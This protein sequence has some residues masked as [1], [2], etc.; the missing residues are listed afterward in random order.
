MIL[1]TKPRWNWLYIPRTGQHT[2]ELPFSRRSGNNRTVNTDSENSIADPTGYCRE[3]VRKHDYEGFLISQFYPK[4][5]QGGYFALRAFA[6]ELA[7][8]QDHTSNQMIGQMRMQFWRDAVKGINDGQPPRHPIAMA[9]H[10]VSQRAHLPMYHLKRVVDARDAELYTPMH[11][12]T[13]S[14]V[15]HAESTFSSMLYL[16]LSM[17]NLTSSTLSHAASHLGC[18]QTFATLLRALPFHAK[19][20]RMII[21]AD[22]TAKNRVSQED[23]F[24]HGPQAAGIED[25]V[26]EFANTGN[27][28]LL[29]A[30]D[31][32]KDEVMGGRVPTRAMPVFLTGVCSSL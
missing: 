31:M 18:A 16:L 20:G 3:F 1:R 28:H 8:I 10:A 26:F 17:L 22:I 21:P 19:N 2:R 30:R 14:L 6:V 29:I 11:L 15:A 32:F 9:L 7:M 4:D 25:A 24:R 27:E 12:T 13:E 23:V 5:L